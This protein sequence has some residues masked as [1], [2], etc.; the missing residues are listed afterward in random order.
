MSNQTNVDLQGRYTSIQEG[1]WWCVKISDSD[2]TVG[3]FYTKLE[4]DRLAST[5]MRAFNDGYRA[6][7]YP[8]TINKGSVNQVTLES[9]QAFNDGRLFAKPSAPKGALGGKTKG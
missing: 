1:I 8:Q 2:Q 3:R 4:S 5:L 7:L 6:D 9:R